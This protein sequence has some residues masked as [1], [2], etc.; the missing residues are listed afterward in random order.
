MPEHDAPWLRKG[1]VKS[2]Y[3]L[4]LSISLSVLC[5]ATNSD[6]SLQLLVALPRPEKKT[7]ST[8]MLKIRS[9]G[10]SKK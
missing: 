2:T 4:V 10:G 3:S 1:N 6:C 5:F 9:L 7:D 8:M